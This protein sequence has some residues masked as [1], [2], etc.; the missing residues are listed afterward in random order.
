MKESKAR[1]I[2]K[3][4]YI[5]NGNTI[6]YNVSVDFFISHFSRR[7]IEGAQV[8]TGALGYKLRATMFQSLC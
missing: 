3:K 6:P 7:V 2:V 4:I 1:E 8:A 5:R